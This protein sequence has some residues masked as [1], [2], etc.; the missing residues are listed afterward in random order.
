MTYSPPPGSN[1]VDPAQLDPAARELLVF[2]RRLFTSTPNLW[3]VKGLIA[4][5]VAVWA[6]QVAMGVSATSPTASILFEWGGNLGTAV[7]E[8]GEYWRLIT[9]TVL[10]GGAIHLAFNMFALW[11]IGQTVERVLGNAG[12]AAT[13]VVSGLAGSIASVIATPDVVSVGAS[14]AVFGILGAQLTGLLSPRVGLPKSMRGRVLRD[15]LFFIGINLLFGF[16]VPNIDNAAH[17]GGLIA[18]LIC[19]AALAHAL[20]PDGIQGRG[21]RALTAVG[22]GVAMLA[23]TLVLVPPSQG[24]VATQ[25]RET[26]IALDTV[27]SKAATVEVDLQK[28]TIQGP[29]AIERLERDVLPDAR[30]LVG[31]A[32]SLDINEEVRDKLVAVAKTRLEMYEAFVDYLRQPSPRSER[33]FTEATDRAR[34]ALSAMQ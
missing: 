9:A 10:H 5:N 23:A 22:M 33:V 6:I 12:F 28:G 30:K 29:E 13:Y 14:G 19:G 2:Q 26:L 1:P 34:A 18:G 27:H 32:R 15:G 31:R 24:G 3:V 8:D 25:Y 17:M 4:L 11:I 7:H 16:S 21:K 20:T